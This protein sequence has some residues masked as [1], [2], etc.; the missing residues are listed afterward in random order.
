[1][2]F[3]HVEMPALA[4]LRAGAVFFVVTNRGSYLVMDNET[5][6]RYH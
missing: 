4:K 3:G 1:M 2:S 5:V 6:I